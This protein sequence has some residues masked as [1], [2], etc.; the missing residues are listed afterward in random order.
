MYQQVIVSAIPQSTPSLVVVHTHPLWGH[1]GSTEGPFDQNDYSV[2]L[3]PVMTREEFESAVEDVN[4]AART[5][6]SG[7]CWGPQ[8]PKVLAGLLIF[9]GLLIG[10]IFMQTDS[11]SFHFPVLIVAAMIYLFVYFVA[12]GIWYRRL[13][14]LMLQ[15][16]NTTLEE[17]NAHYADRNIRWKVRTYQAPHHHHHHHHH[18]GHHGNNHILKNTFIEIEIG[19]QPGFYPAPVVQQGAAPY[20]YPPPQT[21]VVQQQPPYPPQPQPQYVQAPYGDPQ[22]AYMQQPQQSPYPPQQPMQYVGQQPQQQH[23]DPQ[24]AQQPQPQHYAPQQPYDPAQQQHAQFAQQA[25][26]V[27]QGQP[28]MQTPQPPP[29]QSLFTPPDKTNPQPP[30][31]DGSLL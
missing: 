20:P 24:Y 29:Q 15:K 31:D 4:E 26:Y 16:I 27:P 8:T 2:H 6:V 12:L 11:N 1:C 21:V 7:R 23:Y 9:F 25:Q 17:I 3:Q 19:Q 13:M 30:T 22:V 10:G 14:T 28:P 18:D 5:V